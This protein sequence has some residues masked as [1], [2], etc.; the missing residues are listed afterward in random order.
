MHHFYRS[1]LLSRF[2]AEAEDINDCIQLLLEEIDPLITST[3]AMM[4]DYYAI[5]VSKFKSI[6]EAFLGC[7]IFLCI[8]F[9][10]LVIKRA[11]SVLEKKK[12]LTRSMLLMIPSKAFHI[13]QALREA[14]TEM[15]LH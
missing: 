3:E 2:A 4:V 5:V 15:V 13:A 10:F 7:F 6:R 9:Y 12:Q 8:V 14:V 11:I 1:S